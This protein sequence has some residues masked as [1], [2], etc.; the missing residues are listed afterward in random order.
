MNGMARAVVQAVQEERDED[1]REAQGVTAVT[2]LWV[3]TGQTTAGGG[4]RSGTGGGEGE[5]GGGEEE[6]VQEASVV[7]AS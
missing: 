3:P 4:G 6:G 7:K 1:V 2:K 5:G